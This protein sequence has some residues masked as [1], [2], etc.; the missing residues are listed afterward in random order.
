M[1]FSEKERLRRVHALL[2]GEKRIHFPFCNYNY[3]KPAEN[4]TL[5]G[6][7]VITTK[8]TGEEIMNLMKEIHDIFVSDTGKWKK[9][10]GTIRR[11]AI[12]VSKKL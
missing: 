9:Y 6:K 10:G 2:D 3:G 7:Y 1:I 12:A 4:C 11:Q 5:C 8:T